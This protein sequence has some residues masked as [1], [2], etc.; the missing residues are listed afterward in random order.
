MLDTARVNSRTI[1]LVHPVSWWVFCSHVIRFQQR[2]WS[3]H[4]WRTHFQ[5]RE[6]PDTRKFGQDLIRCL[7]TPHMSRRVVQYGVQD[8]VRTKARCYLGNFFLIIF[9]PFSSL[10]SFLF[11]SPSQPFPPPFPWQASADIL[12]PPRGGGGIFPKNIALPWCVPYQELLSFKF[13]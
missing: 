2:S 8:F 10:L 3:S 6:T 1:S 13:A 7:V 12:C 5:D 9:P 11:S 4:L